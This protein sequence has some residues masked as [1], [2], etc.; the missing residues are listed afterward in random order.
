MHLHYCCMETTVI[1]AVPHCLPV[2]CCCLLLPLLFAAIALLVT[3]DAAA[4]AAAAALHCTAELCWPVPLLLLLLLHCHNTRSVCELATDDCCCCCSSTA[5][6][7]TVGI[8]ADATD[9]D[10]A[11]RGGRAAAAPA[12]ACKL[13]IETIQHLS[14]ILRMRWRSTIASAAA[15]PLCA[16]Y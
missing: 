4:A 11:G 1:L 13:T 12:D 10:W 3:F 16:H 9:A 5:T 7:R 8:T 6:M 14:C 2:F 15:P